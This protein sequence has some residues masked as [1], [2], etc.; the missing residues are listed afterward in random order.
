MPELPEVETVA[1]SLRPHLTGAVIRQV[2]V[3]D[4]MVIHAPAP[5]EFS[6]SLEGRR[7]TGISRRGK[8]LL[9][10]LDDG[11]HLIVHLGMTGQ[12]LLFDPAAEPPRF[13][14]VKLALEDGRILW[15]A[16]MRKFGRLTL[17]DDVAGALESL[18]YEPFAPELDA[19]LLQSRLVGRRCPIKSLLLD[20]RVLAG[21][22]NIYA[23]EAL[24]EA[25]IHPCTPAGALSLEEAD[26]L[27]GSVRTVLARG[28][29]NRG[30]TISDYVDGQGQAGSNQAQL[31][32]YGRGGQACHRCGC[33]IERI[34]L[35]GRSTCFCP[36][37]QP[38]RP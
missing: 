30:T 38:Q 19:G 35:S 29:A 26:R 27:L 15:Y 22:G 32:V 4:C 7:I 8:H 13:A 28:I 1:R 16:D 11:R 33:T 14:R 3:L 17:T 9:L 31:R 21:L 18:G 12:L 5:T 37:C 36:A 34:R 2:E 10:A 25:G 23:D 6:R 24:F 20:Q